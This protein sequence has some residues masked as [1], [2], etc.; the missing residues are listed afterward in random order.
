VVAVGGTTGSRST[1][2][3]GRRSTG[4]RASGTTSEQQPEALRLHPE[5]REV[6]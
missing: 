5:S 1:G 3:H 6:G 2:D 4:E